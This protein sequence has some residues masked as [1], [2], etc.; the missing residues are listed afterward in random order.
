MK[1]IQEITNISNVGEFI[2]DN[3]NKQSGC[4][5]IF[6]ADWD[7]EE[8]VYVNE[9]F[10]K[11]LGYEN[12]NDF[13]KSTGN[14]FRGIVYSEDHDTVR[15]NLHMRLSSSNEFFIQKNFRMN[16]KCG[17]QLYVVCHCAYLAASS[18]GDIPVVMMLVSQYQYSTESLTGL[19]RRRSFFKLANDYAAERLQKNMTPVIIAFNLIAMK[20]FNKHYGMEEGDKLLIMFSQLLT[21]CFGLRHC[22][23]FGED[24]FYVYTDKEDL[25]EKLNLVINE[26]KKLNDGKTLEAR[27]GIS[28]YGNEVSAEAA[29]DNAK[30]AADTLSSTVTST[31]VWYD[32]DIELAISKKNYILTNIDK[33]I[34]EGWIEPFYQP[35]IRTYTENICGF[36]ALARWTDPVRGFL[37][38][39]DFIPILEDN[40]FSYKLDMYIAR[41]V[42][43]MFQQRL[44]AGL[45]TVPVSVNISRS[46][47]DYCDP[48]EIISSEC[49]KRGIGRNLIC[50]EITET[51]IMTN[52]E[53]IREAINKFHSAGFEV[54]MDDFGSGYS[55]LNIL[56][57][58]DFDEIKI[59]MGFLRNFNEKSKNIV[60]MAVKMAKKL[61]M[62]TLAEGVETKEHADF[63]RDIGC[64]RIQG[65][66][67][68]KP[69]PYS[70]AVK[71]LEDNNLRT[72]TRELYSLYQKAGLIDVISSHPLALYFYDG[73][74]FSVVYKNTAYIEHVSDISF[75]SSGSI[76]KGSGTVK[77]TIY[78]IFQNL[79]DK[80]IMLGKKDTATFVSNGRYYL[81]TLEAV[82]ASREGHILS[83]AISSEI[84]EKLEEASRS[85]KY[86]RNLAALYDNIYLLD[87][88]NNSIN[89]LVSCIPGESTGD[90]YSSL[91]AIKTLFYKLNVYTDDHEKWNQFSDKDYLLSRINNSGRG[92]FSETFLIKDA[93]G[94]YSWI[95]A[96]V[97]KISD[98]QCEKLLL[99]IK[100]AYINQLDPLEKKDYIRRILDYGY[101]K[102]DDKDNFTSDIWSSLIDEGNLK[103]FWKDTERR[104]MGAS[105][106]FYNYYG[107]S[108]KDDILGKTDEE[109]GWHLDDIPFESDER[110]I[111]LKG[112]AVYN[113]STITIINGRAHNIVAT[114][115]PIY[116][117][118]RIT[119]LVGYFVDADEDIIANGAVRDDRYLDP[120]TG[121]MNAQGMQAAINEFENNYKTNEEEYCYSSLYVEGYNT[122]LHD[123]GE[124]V[125]HKLLRIIA[126]TIKSTFGKATVI[127]RNEGST[128]GICVKNLF[129]NE[130]LDYVSDCVTEINAIKEIEGRSCRLVAH[131]GTT[132]S[133][134]KADFENIIELTNQKLHTGQK[135]RDSNAKIKTEIVPDPYSDIPLPVF[136]TTPRYVKGSTEPTDIIYLFVNKAY[137]ELTGKTKEQL[138]GKGYNELF[139]NTDRKCINIISRAAKGEHIKTKLFDGASYQWINFTASPTDI[140][141]TC[142]VLCE[143]VNK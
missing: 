49:D 37:S 135:G 120:I 25:Q 96:L 60:A 19:P 110:E 43:S 22:S 127:S 141:N 100:P 115:I 90:R 91:D 88:T 82:A 130:V 112:Y 93:D 132:S 3:F 10:I 26:L 106:A 55:S 104:F 113:K 38:P 15:N 59:D 124:A 137:C 41:R 136:L 62:H 114:K 21:N 143:V 101:L 14:S 117:D 74:D 128:F 40:G 69:L 5:L 138:V 86:L 47:F 16:K 105:K 4:I 121:V 57:D 70:E 51:A 89:V 81:L 107:F 35:V 42:I 32:N 20:R 17:R 44:K 72:E 75:T 18:E 8:L 83:A 6:K 36:E 103:L 58:F 31:Y 85:D 84:Y 133:S 125:A 27:I 116:H 123:Y 13:L 87:M 30:V 140:P 131:Y 24:R 23:R 80:V 79:A 56:K 71:Y 54:Y 29:C 73:Q 67:Y 92:F 53:Q 2:L 48:V 28:L 61:G 102:L 64:E 46:D 119:G 95:E 39:G 33:A 126:D 66:Y 9:S 34:S 122:V 7:K 12:E 77:D 65:Y 52:R 142:F 139:P 118:N 134:E 99:C 94:N 68:G 76:D 98:S 45:S 111:L 63:L 11:L 78:H 109:I 50:I 108:S 129:I 1:P 97:E